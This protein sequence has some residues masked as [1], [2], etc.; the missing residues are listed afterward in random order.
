MKK[1]ARS[2]VHQIKLVNVYFEY[3]HNSHFCALILFLIRWFLNND[4]S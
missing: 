3:E 4:C 1:L 2:I